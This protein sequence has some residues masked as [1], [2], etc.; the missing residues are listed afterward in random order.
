MDVGNVSNTT[1]DGRV[2]DKTTKNMGL[3][4]GVF[5][6]S[7]ASGILAAPD[8]ETTKAGVG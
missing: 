3:W 4:Y 7:I 1:K 8:K 5:F 6:R 2:F